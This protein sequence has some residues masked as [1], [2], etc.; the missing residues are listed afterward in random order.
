MRCK[1]RVKNGPKNRQSS[2]GSHCFAQRRLVELSCDPIR[3]SHWAKT[4]ERRWTTRRDTHHFPSCMGSY[5]DI[6][7]QRNLTSIL[8]G[9]LKFGHDTQTPGTKII[10]NT[11]KHISRHNDIRFQNPL[12]LHNHH[13]LSVISL[14][15]DLDK[16][17]SM[18]IYIPW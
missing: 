2:R 14:C 9:K 5:T 1:C 11:K 15:S 18:T 6:K 3:F 4:L 13:A 7:F 16:S 8:F 10:L 12:A 17:S